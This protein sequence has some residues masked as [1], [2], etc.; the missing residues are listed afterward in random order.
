MI[1]KRI[2][3]FHIRMGIYTVLL[4]RPIFNIFIGL[5]NLIPDI[6]VVIILLTLAVRLVLYPFYKKQV[7][8]Q[9][10]LQELQPKLQEIKSQYKDDKEKQAKAMMELYQTNKVHPL[11][12]CLP[13]LIQLPIFLAVYQVLRAGLMNT[14]SFDLLYSFIQQPETISPMFLG[15]FDLSGRSVFL[16]VLAGLADQWPRGARVVVPQSGRQ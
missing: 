2:Y 14:E 1:R 9:K 11:S 3:P 10:A 12:S 8:G 6:G 7:Q 16:A 15:V 13:V 4:Y 5:Y